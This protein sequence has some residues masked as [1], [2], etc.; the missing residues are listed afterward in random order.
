MEKAKGIQRVGKLEA[1]GEKIFSA[2][3]FLCPLGTA[4]G[5]KSA[6]FAIAQRMQRE[7]LEDRAKKRKGAGPG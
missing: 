5:S 6:R 1:V 3:P 2:L 7:H 4:F